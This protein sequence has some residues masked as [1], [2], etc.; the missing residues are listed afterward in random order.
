MLLFGKKERG[1]AQDDFRPQ[2]Q[3]ELSPF[4]Q[5]ERLI[6]QNPSGIKILGTNGA[7]IGRASCRERV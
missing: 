4:T 5:A 1:D 3:E 7:E 2:S 6:A